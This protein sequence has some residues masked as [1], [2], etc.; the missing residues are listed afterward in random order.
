VRRTVNRT[1]EQIDLAT[2][3]AARD[4]VHAWRGHL[5]ITSVAL[6]S[7]LNRA[8]A[9]QMLFSRVERVFYLACEF[10][11]AVNA[12]ELEAH[13]D[14]DAADPLH[15]ARLAFSAIGAER[16][17][18]V[19]RHADIAGGARA[20]RGRRQCVAATEERL[21]RTQDSVDVLIAEFARRY[22]CD[23]LGLP[24]PASDAPNLIATA[25]FPPDTLAAL[26]GNAGCES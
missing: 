12:R 5:P 11:A 18:D 23:E 8:I 1:P 2:A 10:W 6:L 17:V 16:I 13:L 3:L 14:P 25:A 15:D 22:L 9:G 26:R 21:L 19:L 7:I 24:V 20:Q 4:G